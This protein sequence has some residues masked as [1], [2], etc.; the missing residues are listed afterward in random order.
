VRIHRLQRR[1]RL[2]QPLDVVFAF[3]ARARNLERITR[4]AVSQLLAS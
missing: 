3:F 1:Q 2:D 4:E